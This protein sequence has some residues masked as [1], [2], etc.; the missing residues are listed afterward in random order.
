MM[1]YKTINGLVEGVI[2]SEFGNVQEFREFKFSQI[3]LS[4]KRIR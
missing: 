1:N 2:E 4:Q 3:D